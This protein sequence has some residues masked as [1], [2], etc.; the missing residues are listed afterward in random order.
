[1]SKI[2]I[3]GFHFSPPNHWFYQSIVEIVKVRLLTALDFQKSIVS[4]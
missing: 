2:F 4:S 1:M 3:K